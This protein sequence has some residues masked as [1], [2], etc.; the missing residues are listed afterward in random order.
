RGAQPVD[1]GD[2]PRA[3]PAERHAVRGQVRA[4]AGGVGGRARGVGAG[5]EVQVGQGGRDEQRSRTAGGDQARGGPGP[6]ALAGQVAPAVGGQVGEPGRGPDGAED[7]P[8]QHE[9]DQAA[10][11]PGLFGGNG[12]APQDGDAHPQRD[13]QG[14]GPGPGLLSGVLPAEQGAGGAAGQ[15]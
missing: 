14:Q 4:P 6:A 11:G 8:G 13:E 7:E 1:G 3:D 9:G 12:R 2:L 10:G 15:D 5:A